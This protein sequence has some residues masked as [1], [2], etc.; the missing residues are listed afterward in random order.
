M[1]R[2][3]DSSYN[4]LSSQA[5][6]ATQFNEATN[7]GPRSTKRSQNRSEQLDA[8]ANRNLTTSANAK[9]FYNKRSSNNP[10]YK[11]AAAHMSRAASA[12]DAAQMRSTAQSAFNY[13][14]NNLERANRSGAH[15]NQILL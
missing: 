8:A 13:K 5:R 11:N 4:I 2:A 15:K 14:L 3:G 6:V 9:T 10:T 1:K 7:N 12:I